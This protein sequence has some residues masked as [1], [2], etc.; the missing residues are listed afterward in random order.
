MVNEAHGSLPTERRITI[1]NP[2]HTIEAQG[3]WAFPACRRGPLTRASPTHQTIPTASGRIGV[4]ALSTF[5][6]RGG[7]VAR[8]MMCWP[9]EMSCS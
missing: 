7:E 6:T 9:A 8:V 1:L 2:G 3:L 4:P 5:S